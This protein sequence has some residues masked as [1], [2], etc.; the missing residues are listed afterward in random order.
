MW[1]KAMSSFLK[2]PWDVWVSSQ[3]Q[4]QQQQQQQAPVS[5]LVG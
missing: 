5:L 2:T 4:Q 1:W 3:Q